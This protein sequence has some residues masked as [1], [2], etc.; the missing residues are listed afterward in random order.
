MEFFLGAGPVAR[1][2]RGDGQRERRGRRSRGSSFSSSS[3]SSP[4]FLLYK[5]SNFQVQGPHSKQLCAITAV[6]LIGT[7]RLLDCCAEPNWAANQF[8]SSRPTQLSEHTYIFMREGVGGGGGA[9]GFF[10]LFAGLKFPFGLLRPQ[11]WF[12]AGDQVDASWD[13]E[14]KDCKN[15]WHV[16][17]LG[18]GSANDLFFF[19]FFKSNTQP[20]HLGLSKTAKLTSTAGTRPILKLMLHSLLTILLYFLCLFFFNFYKTLLTRRL[21]RDAN[22]DKHP[23]A[24]SGAPSASI[25]A[26]KQDRLCPVF[27]F[28]PDWTSS[29]SSSDFQKLCVFWSFSQA[30]PPSELSTMTFWEGCTSKYFTQ[31]WQCMLGIP[32]V[33]KRQHKAVIICFSWYLSASPLCNYCDLCDANVLFPAG[34][35]GRHDSLFFFYSWDGLFEPLLSDPRSILGFHFEGN[36]RWR[37]AQYNQWPTGNWRQQMREFWRCFVLFFPSQKAMHFIPTRR[38]W[39][40]NI[41][42]L[43]QERQTWNGH[44]QTAKR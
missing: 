38:Y 20:F 44:W 8:P 17:V 19:V 13:S 23:A 2:R 32:L 31:H 21:L 36:N 29:L 18:G 4:R 37:A 41:L 7:L 6:I 5:P 22:G 27:Q 16:K 33:A 3:L 14:W 26:T 42:G 9:G 12:S 30:V 1:P 28:H 15:I 11:R 25:R 35:Y 34:L 40:E 24:R 10:F 43:Q 39:K